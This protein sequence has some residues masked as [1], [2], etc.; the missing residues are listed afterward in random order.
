[1]KN[2]HIGEN[3]SGHV[4]ESL[5]DPEF[6]KFYMRSKMIGEIAQKVY[7][8]RIKS[9]LSQK[10][11]ADKAQT[12]QPVIARLESGKDKRVPSLELLNKIASATNTPLN[13]SFG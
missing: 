8:L 9:G 1:M 6:Q 5:D 2:K 3:I 11:I 4:E 12:T 7:E 10:E 13:I